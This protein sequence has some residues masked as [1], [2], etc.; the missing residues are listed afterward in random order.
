MYW[1]MPRPCLR[2]YHAQMAGIVMNGEK[3]QSMDDYGYGYGYG[4]EEQK[5]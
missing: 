4:L 1:P 3:Q 5:S 2:P